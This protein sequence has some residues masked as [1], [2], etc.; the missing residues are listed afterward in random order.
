[1][2]GS[3]VATIV[4]LSAARSIPRSSPANTIRVRRLP[5]R[6]ASFAFPALIQTS[7]VT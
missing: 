2:S 6:Y 5:R 3:A 7:Y 4:W 1:M